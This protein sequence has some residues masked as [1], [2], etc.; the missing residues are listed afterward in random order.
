M[1]NERLEQIAWALFL[2]LLGVLSLAPDRFIPDG[3]WGIGV[4]LI[5]LGLNAAR[6]YFGIALS[7]FT[8][9]VGSLFFLSG[10]GDLFG[11]DFPFFPI[12]LIGAGLYMIVREV[13][14]PDEEIDESDEIKEK[15]IPSS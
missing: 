7:S 14:K 6:Y 15:V 4:G 5:M 2:I 13:R 1:T 3:S 11:F 9:I 10:I 12:I 8:L